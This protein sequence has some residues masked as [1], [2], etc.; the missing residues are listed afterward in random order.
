[1]SSELQKIRERSV[2]PS[3]LVLSFDD[4]MQALDLLQQRGARVRGWEGWLR[5]PDGRLGHSERHQGTADLSAIAAAAAFELCRRSMRE[6]HQAFRSAPD[7]EA[8]EL[9]FC[10]THDV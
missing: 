1:M 9:L 10:I 2:S 7:R 8:S 5:Y 4:A 6:A 3:E